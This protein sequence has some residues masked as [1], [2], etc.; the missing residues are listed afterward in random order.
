MLAYLLGREKEKA[1]FNLTC[2]SCESFN[3]FTFPCIENLPNHA[4][5]SCHKEQKL[6]RKPLFSFYLTV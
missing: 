4:L 5:A 2:S 6:L 1:T 3:T